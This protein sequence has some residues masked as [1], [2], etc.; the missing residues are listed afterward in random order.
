MF[1]FLCASFDL[2]LPPPVGKRAWAIPW[3]LLSVAKGSSS[4]LATLGF[5][6]DILSDSFRYSFHTQCLHMHC[7]FN[8]CFLSVPFCWT[9]Q[10]WLTYFSAYFLSWEWLPVLTHG[11]FWFIIER[12]VTSCQRIALFFPSHFWFAAGTVT[13]SVDHIKC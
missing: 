2:S 8:S 12:A 11:V 9:A 1:R 3:L 4:S 7:Y 6:T 10:Y 5:W 13:K